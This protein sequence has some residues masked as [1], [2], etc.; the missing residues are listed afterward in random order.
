MIHRTDPEAPSWTLWRDL[1]RVEQVG[2]EPELL[3]WE[4]AAWAGP[5]PRQVLLW[6]PGSLAWAVQIRSRFPSAQLTWLNPEAAW[7]EL[8]QRLPG[9]EALVR[10]QA[11]PRQWLA[12]HRQSYDWILSAQGPRPPAAWASQEFYRLVANRLT[13]E[14][15]FLTALESPRASPLSRS[16]SATLGRVFG[17]RQ[18]FLGPLG[19]V[20]LAAPRPFGQ[21]SSPEALSFKPQPLGQES[22]AEIFSDL[23]A[24]LA[25]LTLP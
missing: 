22:G 17:H 20:W 13:R 14:G 10:R 4:L 16:T 24:P 12:G 15:V 6:G 9:G 1:E 5:M 7:V 18:E 19:P 8:A 25:R 21:T 11:D 3:A 2:S 23:E